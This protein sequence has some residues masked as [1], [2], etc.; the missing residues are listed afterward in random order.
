MDVLTRKM[1]CQ[2]LKEMTDENHR[3]LKYVKSFNA[4]SEMLPELYPSGIPQVQTK[5]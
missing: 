4:I 5:V 3:Y 2:A 1:V